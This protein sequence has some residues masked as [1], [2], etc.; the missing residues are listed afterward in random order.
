MNI[1]V[2]TGGETGEREVSIRSAKNIAEVIDF[3]KVKT[4]IFPEERN[5]FIS[6]ASQFDVVIPVIHGK[7]GEDGSL[8]GLCENLNLPYIFSRITTHAIAI[9]K[10]FTKEIVTSLGI[11][12]SQTTDTFPCFAKPRNGG[13]SVASKYCQS[14]EEYIELQEQHEYI[15]FIKEV[16]IKGREFTVGVIEQGGKAVVLPVI[17]IVPKGAFFDFE[18]KYN[19]LNLAQEICPANIDS[20]VKTEL[21]RQALLVH[22]H[23]QTRH[24]SRSDFIV[25]EDHQVYFL[26]IN[27][28]PGMTGT[29]LIPKMLAEEHMSLKELI[30][31]WCEEVMN[32]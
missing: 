11:T 22:E 26:E 7:G 15:E 8:Q 18:N 17:E 4:F 12:T 24:I 21:Q 16:P 13:S 27:T 9:D 19:P 32:K 30:K 1:A 29:S 6:E 31:N 10:Q 5:H 28:I 14:K 3:G 20:E 2:I 23:L 25:T